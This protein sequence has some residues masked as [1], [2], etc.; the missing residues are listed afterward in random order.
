MS[1]EAKIPLNQNRNQNRRRGRG[2]NRGGQGG[3]NQGNRIDSR[4]RGNAPQMLEKYKKLAHDASL[5]GDRVLTEYYLQF[6]DHYFRVVADMRSQKDDQRPPRQHDR[7]QPFGTDDYD[8][9]DR[10][11]G[12]RGEQPRERDRYDEERPER[13]DAREEGQRASEGQEVAP[14]ENPFVREAREPR[15]PRERSGQRGRGRGRPANDARDD[16]T[17]ATFDAAVLPPSIAREEEETPRPARTRTR[18]PRPAD[19]EGDEALEAVS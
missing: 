13:D 6:A 11:D 17:E 12:A 5:N 7:D 2:N 4:A 9:E 14:E 1:E 15:E 16:E 8:S 10:D 19:D 3:G 18:R